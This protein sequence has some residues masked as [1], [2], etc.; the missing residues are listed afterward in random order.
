MLRL[1]I[2]RMAY[3]P[4]ARAAFWVS[5]AT[6]LF[7]A[8]VPG[9][10]G[11]IVKSDTE[12]HWLAFL[13]LPALAFVGWPKMGVVKLWLCFATFGASIEV[14]QWAMNLGRQAQW[15]DWTHDLIATT[16]SL[17]IAWIARL[18]TDRLAP[19]SAT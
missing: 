19:D 3:Q 5:A 11:E 18:A 1:R 14:A 7:L 16:I 4:F 13:I 9:P 10:L 17:A 12:R 15:S 6:V 8:L 2:S